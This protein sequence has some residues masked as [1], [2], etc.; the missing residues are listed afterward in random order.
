[1]HTIYYKTCFFVVASMITEGPMNLQVVDGETATLNC[2]VVAEPMPTFLWLFEDTVLTN[3]YRHHINT[4]DA[5]TSSLTIFDIS[6]SDTG[7]YTCLVVNQHGND[8]ATAELQVLSK[9]CSTS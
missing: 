6:V 2:S 3:D 1:M 5:G 4:L 7:N 8:S 9:L